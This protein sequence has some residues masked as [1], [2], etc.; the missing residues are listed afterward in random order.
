MITE[1]VEYIDERGLVHK[2]ENLLFVISLI[3]SVV[4]FF[5]LVISIIGITIFFGLLTLTLFAHAVSMAYIRMNG[6]ELS[7]NQFGDLYERVNGLCKRMG[8]REIPEVYIME[9]GGVLNAFAT[10]ILG[11]FGRDMVILYSDIVELMVN[12][13]EEELD[14]IIAHEL[15]HIKRNHIGK[16]ALTF[17]AMWIP[18][19]GEAYSRACE[20]TADRMAAVYTEKPEKAARALTVLAAGKYLFRFVNKE[21]YLEQYNRKKGFFISLTE[22]LSTHPAIPLRIYE[23][24]S[25]M[26]NS[27]VVVKKK[28]KFGIAIVLLIMIVLGGL[29]I[30]GTNVMFEKLGGLADEFLL[31]EGT[32]LVEATINGDVAEVEKLLDEGADPNE[33]AEEY[34]STALIVA[35]DNDQVQV[36]KVLLERGADPNLADSYDYT[37]LMAAV[38][39]ESTDMVELLIKAGADPRFEDDEGTSAISIAEDFGYEDLVKIL[40]K[41]KGN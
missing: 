14:F 5:F 39:M 40:K 34:G 25:F 35:A 11:F 12:G 26:G 41:G 24:E 4:M 6:I 16:R 30:W 38:Y 1:K 21:E 23:I 27:T 33:Q 20:Y 32:P 2:R 17:L 3:I 15:A 8:M 13:D 28:S 19:L 29:F 22:L 10:R 9:S 18:F 36:A 7:E 37:A 31:G